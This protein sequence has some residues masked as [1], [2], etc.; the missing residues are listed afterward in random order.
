MKQA[1]LDVIDVFPT[2]HSSTIVRMNR[3][4]VSIRQLQQSNSRNHLEPSMDFQQQLTMP[5]IRST[6]K[7]PPILNFGIERITPHENKQHQKFMQ[8]GEQQNENYDDRDQVTGKFCCD[9]LRINWRFAFRS[10]LIIVGHKIAR[11][12]QQCHK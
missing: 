8:K 9:L 5:L 2:D 7:S 3:I 10:Q 4:C 12:V 11:F 6:L 1:L